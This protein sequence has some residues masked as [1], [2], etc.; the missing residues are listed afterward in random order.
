[1]VEHMR[2]ATQTG[3]RWDISTLTGATEPGH[4]QARLTRDDARR[5]AVNFAKLPDLV[6]MKHSP[7]DRRSSLTA[8]ITAVTYCLFVARGGK[9][10]SANS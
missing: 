9:R 5:M 1:M 4:Q 8:V 7:L 2:D 6:A 10:R 3:R